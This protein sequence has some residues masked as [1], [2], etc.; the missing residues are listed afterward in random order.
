MSDWE[1]TLR[2]LSCEILPSHRDQSRIDLVRTL[3]Y[4]FPQ[5]LSSTGYTKRKCF[6]EWM[7]PFD[8]KT[9]FLLRNRSK[10]PDPSLIL[11]NFHM[12]CSF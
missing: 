6:H 2:V 3:T 12:D 5:G 11:W 7:I 8:Q 10:V 9:L 4:S 1:L